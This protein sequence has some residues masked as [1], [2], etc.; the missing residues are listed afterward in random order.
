MRAKGHLTLCLHC[1]AMQR[2]AT[3]CIYL[4]RAGGL[5]T[6]SCIVP[7]GEG[8]NPYPS[9]SWGTLRTCIRLGRWTSR[10]R[11][12]SVNPANCSTCM[13]LRYTSRNE[14]QI[15]TG[16]WKKEKHRQ[17]TG[18]SLRHNPL[19]IPNRMFIFSCRGAIIPVRPSRHHSLAGLQVEVDETPPFRRIHVHRPTGPGITHRQSL[20]R[21]HCAGQRR[22]T[23]GGGDAYHLHRCRQGNG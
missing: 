10:T 22:I 18:S 20:S 2:S 11:M 1:S 14:V 15:A 8:G 16:R 13:G 23:E 19:G 12:R 17:S 7:Q 4:H 21:R 9:V 6:L 3:Q 5:K